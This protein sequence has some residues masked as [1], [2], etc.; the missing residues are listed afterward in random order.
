MGRKTDIS[1]MGD[2]IVAAL[3]E[4]SDD[5]GE[6]VENAVDKVSKATVSTVKKTS[7]KLT[8]DYR[9]GWRNRVKVSSRGRYVR[10]IHNKTDY[11]LVHLLEHGHAKVGGGT[12]PAI[13]HLE[14]A[15]RKAKEQLRKL[16]EEAIQ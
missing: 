6:A 9:K 16:I 3:K 7:P 14:P 15:E 1:G 2:A 8:G 13:P 12:V 5:V 10:E 11:Q 4:Y